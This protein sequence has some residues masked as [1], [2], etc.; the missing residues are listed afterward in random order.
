MVLPDGICWP[1]CL[2]NGFVTS[3]AVVGM[4]PAQQQ[5][6]AAGDSESGW[7]RA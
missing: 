3:Y 1:Q 4:V 6:R 2:V 7:Q 5:V